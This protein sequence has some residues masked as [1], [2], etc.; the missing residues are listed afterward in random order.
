MAD[1]LSAT[2]PSLSDFER[3]MQ[4]AFDGLPADVRRACADLLLR[5]AD[6]APDDMLDEMEIEDPYE[7]TGLYD[8]VALTDR[9]VMTSPTAPTP[10]GSTAGRSSRSGSTAATWPSTGWCTTCWCT[11][12]PTTSAGPTTTSA[13][14]TTG[15]SERGVGRCGQRPTSRQAQLRSCSAWVRR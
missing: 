2:A 3:L 10:S 15:R 13:R 6:F 1:R 4:R 8:G 7:L 5:V 12:S 11:R 9:S 14:S